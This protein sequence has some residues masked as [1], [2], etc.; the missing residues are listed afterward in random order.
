MYIINIK[1]LI[2]HAAHQEFTFLL[3]FCRYFLKHFCMHVDN[4]YYQFGK[5]SRK[6]NKNKRNMSICN[7]RALQLKGLTY[8]IHT[9]R[10]R[11]QIFL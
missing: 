10:K 7:I 11:Q 3:D 1:M 4:I 9:K 6:V 5:N 2:F 8:N